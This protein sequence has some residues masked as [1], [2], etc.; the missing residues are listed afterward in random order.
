MVKSKPEQKQTET[1]ALYCPSKASLFD[2]LLKVNSV[3]PVS[4]GERQGQ[5][6]SHV[7]ATLCVF[8]AAVKK[9]LIIA[10]DTTATI[11]VA[12]TC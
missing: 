10:S 2:L 4:C 8:L 3:S 7:D 9:K 12:Q 1:S 11:C 6:C 5:V